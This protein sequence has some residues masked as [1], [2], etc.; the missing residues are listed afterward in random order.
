M[1]AVADAGVR[2]RSF[3]QR[4]P[5]E[6][7]LALRRPLPGRRPCR[8]NCWPRLLVIRS[9]ATEKSAAG[10]P[11]CAYVVVRPP[12]P[13]IRGTLR[14]RSPSN[15]MGSVGRVPPDG[16]PGARNEDDVREEPGLPAEERQT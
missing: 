15:L 10:P 2:D 13:G 11:L 7:T 1:G 3:P 4:H 12:K 6:I 9:E 14:Q 5:A 16:A 8:A